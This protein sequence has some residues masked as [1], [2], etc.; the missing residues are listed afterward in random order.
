[1]SQLSLKY[2]REYAAKKGLKKPK[3]RFKKERNRRYYLHQ[4]LKG[5]I[6][7]KAEKR[8]IFVPSGKIPITLQN[9]INELCRDYG[10]SAQIIIT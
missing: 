2:Q 3:N 8:T 9:Y 7:L 4:R 10:Y 6:K 1:M 5:F